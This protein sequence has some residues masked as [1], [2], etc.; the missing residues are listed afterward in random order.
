MKLHPSNGTAPKS[1]GI[2][3]ETQNSSG[4]SEIKLMMLEI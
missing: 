3:V 2:F 4:A 1:L